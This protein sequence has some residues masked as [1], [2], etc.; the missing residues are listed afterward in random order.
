MKSYNNLKRK[1]ILC[2][3]DRGQIGPVIPN[4]KRYEI[5]QASIIKH[6]LSNIIYG[7]HLLKQNLSIIYVF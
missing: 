2:M 3:M 4:G 1:V 6:K 7:V 5:V